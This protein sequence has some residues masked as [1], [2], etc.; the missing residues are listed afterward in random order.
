MI[1]EIKQKTNYEK[2]INELKNA[3]VITEQRIAT[4]LQENTRL[5]DLAIQRSK[6]IEALKFKFSNLG[7]KNDFSEEKRIE[8]DALKKSK[9]DLD[10]LKLQ[11]EKEINAYKI[12]IQQLVHL[13]DSKEIELKGLYEI[14]DKKQDDIFAIQN[15]VI[16]I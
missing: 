14:N 10:K 11:Y 16:R 5:N 7:G 15:K 2:V 8:Y 12:K 6:E 4:A 1:I 13:L 3:L 9:Y